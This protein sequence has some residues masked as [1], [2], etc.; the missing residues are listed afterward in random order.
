MIQDLVTPVSQSQIFRLNARCVRFDNAMVAS[1]S[2]VSISSRLCLFM[3]IFGPHAMSDLSPECALKPIGI[4]DGSASSLKNA[5]P[6]RGLTMIARRWARIVNSK[7]CCTGLPGP[8]AAVGA[9]EAA[10][11]AFVVHDDCKPINLKGQRFQGMSKAHKRGG[12]LDRNSSVLSEA[13]ILG[14]ADSAL[15]GG[16]HVSSFA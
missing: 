13:L 9:A 3:A 16:K 2:G 6:L 10:L 4:G 15:F 14:C 12:T 8:V 1:P 11:L 7:H 5:W